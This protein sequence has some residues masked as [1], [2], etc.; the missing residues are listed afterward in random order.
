ML[1]YLKECLESLTQSKTFRTGRKHRH[2]LPCGSNCDTPARSTGTTQEPVR[3]AES[4]A[5]PRS[6]EADSA[7]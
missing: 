2:L 7:F 3:N 1:R 4:Q 6:T 5:Q